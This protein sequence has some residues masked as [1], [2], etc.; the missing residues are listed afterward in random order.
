M[1]RYGIRYDDNRIGTDSESF[2]SLNKFNPSFGF[3]YSLND[4]NNIYF[5]SGTSFET[6]TL[7]ELSNNPNSNGLN[8]NLN[9]SSS[10]NYEIGWRKTNSK[11][12]FEAIAC[13]LYTSP[14]PRDVEESRM[15]SSA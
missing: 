2:I 11:L 13:L 1:F 4:A 3:S 5:S 14:S 7:N 9:P 8:K 15:P 6:P 12:I 10:I